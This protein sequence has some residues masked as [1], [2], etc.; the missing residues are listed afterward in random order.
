MAMA[1]PSFWIWTSALTSATWHRSEPVPAGVAV[2]VR[3]ALALLGGPVDAVVVGDG[4]AWGAG[5]P[6]PVAPSPSANAV[7]AMAARS[8]S[9]CGCS[10]IEPSGDLVVR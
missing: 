7:S 3:A 2:V 9:L 6:Q 10:G 8:A 5:L 4:P 1:E